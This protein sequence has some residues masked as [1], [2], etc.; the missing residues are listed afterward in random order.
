MFKQGY[1]WTYI[2]DQMLLSATFTVKFELVF[3][4]TQENVLS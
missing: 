1:S 4:L 2:L 3:V